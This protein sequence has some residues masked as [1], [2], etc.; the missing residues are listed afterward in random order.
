MLNSTSPPL[1]DFWSLKGW[2]LIDCNSSSTKASLRFSSIW[3][4]SNPKICCLQSLSSIWSTWNRDSTGTTHCSTICFCLPRMISGCHTF[5][6]TEACLTLLKFESSARVS[7][8]L[9]VSSASR[10]SMSRS[11]I[12]RSKTWLSFLNTALRCAAIF[13]SLSLSYL[14]LYRDLQVDE[15]AEVIEEEEGEKK[16]GKSEERRWDQRKSSSDN[17]WRRLEEIDRQQ[18]SL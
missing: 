6:A 12:E 16:G 11:L 10:V 4:F 17:R 14:T 5:N 18:R 13:L 8:I 1:I 2:Y 9:L 7:R 15:C 3:A